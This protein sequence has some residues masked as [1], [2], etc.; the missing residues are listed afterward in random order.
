MRKA[1]D[2]VYQEPLLTNLSFVAYGVSRLAVIPETLQNL[3][4]GMAE[5]K[6]KGSLFNSVGCGKEH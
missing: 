5:V 2:T 1:T 6:D 3:Q 4:C